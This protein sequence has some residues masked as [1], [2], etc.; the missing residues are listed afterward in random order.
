MSDV[1]WSLLGVFAVVLV[2][3]L[4]VGFALSWRDRQRERRK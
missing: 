3:Y 2:G 4:I 1:F